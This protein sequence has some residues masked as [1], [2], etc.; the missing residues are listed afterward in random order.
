MELGPLQKKWVKV[1]RDNAH[2]QG[3]RNLGYLDEKTGTKKFCCLGM[4]LLVLNKGVWAPPTEGWGIS[5]LQDGYSQ[6]LLISY[7]EM[8]FIGSAGD[9]IEPYKDIYHSLAYMND[10]GVLWSEIADLAESNPKIMFE[11][12]V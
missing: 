4:A 12:S 3:R 6:K 1:L 9:L 7:Q 11:V 10:K 8:G 2:L 5:Y